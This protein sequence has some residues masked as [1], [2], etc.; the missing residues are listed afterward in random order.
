MPYIVTGNVFDSVCIFVWIC[1]CEYACLG[2]CAHTCMCCDTSSVVVDYWS[3]SIL[4][5][6]Q[7]LSLSMELRSHCSNCTMGTWKVGTMQCISHIMWHVQPSFE[8]IVLSPTVFLRY[9]LLGK[10]DCVTRLLQAFANT[11]VCVLVYSRQGLSGSILLICSH[12]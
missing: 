9:A 3:C 6:T 1:V 10:H 11:C 8:L 12:C 7:L 5:G 4:I 2:V